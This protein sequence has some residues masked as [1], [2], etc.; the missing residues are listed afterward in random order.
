M[1]PLFEP[2]SNVSGVYVIIN[3][4]NGHSYVGSSA[5]VLKRTWTHLRC[6]KGSAIV[7]A[8]I[9]KHGAENF[10]AHILETAPRGFLPEREAWW[11]NFLR[12]EYNAS[13]LTIAGGRVMR[14]E[15][16]AKLRAANLG[17]K[18]TPEHKAAISAGNKGR[19]F[20]PETRQKIGQ[21]HRGTKHRPESIEKMRAVEWTPERR[22]NMSAS[23]IGRLVSAET[24]A[25]KSAALKG[26]PWSAARRAADALKTDKEYR[27]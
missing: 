12:P 14:E 11:M 21:A 2:M 13:D 26:K 24:R 10:E 18:L 22:A 16:K 20:E 23:G 8:A 27:A 4:V 5:N 3:L 25:K 15:T 9:R 17:K 6:K 19:I 1:T 7:A